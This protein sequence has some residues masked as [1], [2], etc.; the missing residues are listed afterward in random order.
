MSWAAHR[1]TSREEDQAYSLLGLFG[2]NMPLIYGEREKAFIR[3]QEEIIKNSTDHSIFAWQPTEFFYF[4]SDLIFAERPSLFSHAAKI[5][6]TTVGVASTPY[7]LTNGGLRFDALRLC[8]SGKDHLGIL[9]CRYYDDVEGPIAVCLRIYDEP[10]KDSCTEG[11]I[12][13]ANT[14]QNRFGRGRT[15]IVDEST[16]FH[17]IPKPCTL[18]RYIPSSGPPIVP[19]TYSKIWLC[20]DETSPVDF[21]ILDTC[22]RHRWNTSTRVLCLS[23]H[24]ITTALKIRVAP[25]AVLFLIISMREYEDSKE[26]ELGRDRL[27]ARNTCTDAFWMTLTRAFSSSNCE[28][29]VRDTYA[30]ASH[31][32]ENPEVEVNGTRYY[33]HVKKESRMGDTVYVIRIGRG[34]KDQRERKRVKFQRTHF[35]LK[36]TESRRRRAAAQA[37]IR[38]VRSSM[39]SSSK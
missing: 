1:S 7:Q 9:N 5:V 31:M 27:A 19:P 4:Q 36:R 34:R 18:L 29:V 24:G 11:G 6:S 21:E 32:S 13:L 8:E 10:S 33:A 35:T 26:Q 2:I 38:A 30:F 39:L 20:K 22:P 14:D 28:E 12:Y 3:L 37:E 17:A 16:A 15:T 25:T 23:G